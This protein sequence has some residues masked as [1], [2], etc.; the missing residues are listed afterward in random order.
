V[1]IDLLASILLTIA[2]SVSAIGY[3]NIN[4]TTS[5]GT[6]W[7]AVGLFENEQ[8]ITELHYANLHLGNLEYNCPDPY[9]PDCV[10]VRPGHPLK[11]NRARKKKNKTRRK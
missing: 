6:A 3:S 7:V 11:S 4:I 2:Q 10:I 8:S 5:K 9:R 1:K